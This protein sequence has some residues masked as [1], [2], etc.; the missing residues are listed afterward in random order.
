MD[1]LL[2]MVIY[3]NKNRIMINDYKT[4]LSNFRNFAIDIDGNL[5]DINNAT[6]DKEYYCIECGNQLNIRDGEIRVKHFYHLTI[7]ECNNESYLHKVYKKVIEDCK[8]IY[9]YDFFLGKPKSLVFDFVKL[10]HRIGEFIPDCYGI[11]QKECEDYSEAEVI[12]EIHHTNKVNLKKLQKLEN[13]NIFCIEIKAQSFETIEEIK[14]YI[15]GQNYFRK[16]LHN[17]FVNTAMQKIINENDQL[18]KE[19]LSLKNIIS[20]KENKK[21]YIK[22]LYLNFNKICKNGSYFYSNNKSVIT[23]FVDKKDSLKNSQLTIVFEDQNK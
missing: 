21:D 2:K 17:P 7:V 18:K 5:V 14:N 16:V 15:T 4:M 22:K 20:E 13:Y 8:T 9:Y 10:E 11:V 3:I 1:Q 23:A 6:K 19:I 12:I